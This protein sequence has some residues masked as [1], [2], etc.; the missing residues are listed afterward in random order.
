MNGKDTTEHWKLYEAGVS[1]NN[2][3]HG[4]KSYYDNI[5]ANIAFSAGDQWR[6]V[7]VEDLPKPV[8]NIIKR[9][10][11][12]KVASLTSNN[13]G[14]QLEPLEYD[15]ANTTPKTEQ[16]FA[17]SEVA[18]AEIRNLLNKFNFKNR[19]RD[20]LGD[21]FD[22]G[23]MAMHF[24][25]DVNK[26]PY[27][28]RFD[29]VKGEIC[30]E[31]V[32]GSN[33]M[34]GNANN[35]NVEVQPYIIIVGRDLAKNLKKEAETYKNKN[36]ELDNDEDYTY[37]SADAGKI[38]VETDKYGKALYIIVYERD[39]KTG[40]IK[41]TKCTKKA[42]IY[43]DV[44]TGYDYYPVAWM[45]WEKQKNQ[46]HGRAET[47]GLIPNQIAINKMFAMV[48]YFLMLKAFPPTVYDSSRISGLTNE[49]NQLIPVN[50]ADGAN[51]RNL[52]GTLEYGDFSNK[53]IE[54]INLAINLTKDLMGVSD[55]SLGTIDPKNTSAIIA[56]QRATVVPLENVKANVNEF[57]DDTVRILL[58]IMGTK[59][60]NRPFIVEKEGIKKAYT[61]DFNQLKNIWLDIKSNVGDSTY[62]SEISAIQT[63][64][65]LLQANRIEF[66]D[67]LERLPKNL[68]PK[69]DELIKKI[70]ETTPNAMEYQSMA[71]LF[72]SLPP[73]TQAQLKAMPDAQMEAALKEMMANQ[74]MQQQQAE[75]NNMM[76]GV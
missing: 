10:K 25:F 34:F 43:K 39:E 24:Y 3:L 51:F 68:I 11:Q 26:K 65:N 59:Y 12:F 58:D 4:D 53:I 44:D 37:Q 8:F 62:W 71:E 63:L 54:V 66:I 40:K 6:N 35:P 32:D 14:V 1:Y 5:D 72:D 46:Y 15:E 30:M 16:E 38:E 61:Y 2:E 52:I 69:L 42:Y 23:D 64:D 57:V 70:K 27:K 22:T 76:A 45:N 13:I 47:T 18:N 33:V 17:A 41:A 21:A 56:V 36:V 7:D 48:I 50:L 75:I 73:E 29:G 67:Y 55:A 74:P 9:V 49:V 28:G 60:G 31:L 19:L 20:G